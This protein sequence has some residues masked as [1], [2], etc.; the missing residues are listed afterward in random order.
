M[1]NENLYLKNAFIMPGGW[2]NFTGRVGQYNKD[3]HRSFNIRF[4]PGVNIDAGDLEN[5][6]AAGWN[7]KEQVD[8]HEGTTFYTL[9]VKVN[10]GVSPP[11]IIR[12]GD[13]TQ[14]E[15]YLG[16]DNVG[17]LDA[18]TILE[19]DVEINPYNY[20]INGNR[21]TAAYLKKLWV[22]VEESQFDIDMHAR[23]SAWQED[24]PAFVD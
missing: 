4:D 22:L 2:R 16:P 11:E 1:I 5:L 20:D 13:K 10:F 24:D 19:A 7:I 17:A 3:G 6:L 8:E 12:Q 14:I 23:R 21:G 18:F 15:V 9:S